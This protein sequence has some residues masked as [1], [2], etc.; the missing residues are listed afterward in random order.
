MRIIRYRDVDGRDRH[1]IVDGATAFEAD[2]DPFSQHGLLRG[3]ELGPADALTLLPPVV[4][5]K[6][7][8]VGLN[9]AAHVTENDPNRVVPDEPVLFMK[10]PSALVASGQAIVVAHPDHR[11]DYEAE[12]AIVIGRAGRDI[13]EADAPGFV[14]G[15][16]CGND[17]SDRTLQ[18][19]DGQWVRAKGFDTYCPL[20]PWIETALDPADLS[21]VS[22]RNGEV[23]QSQRTSA[24]IFKPAF[25]VSFISRVM[26]LEPGDVIMTGTPEGVGPL[27]PGD[28]IEVEIEGIGVLAN[29]VVA[30]S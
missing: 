27:Q 13:A 1:G 3:A 16:A 20:G 24:M 8:C 5:G 2:G 10:P 6:I 15:Y 18:K 14:L 12:L 26:T 7:V 17:V 30:A 19:K 4:P 28:A 21:V 29:R 22:R 23:K 9:Y 11:T 25:L